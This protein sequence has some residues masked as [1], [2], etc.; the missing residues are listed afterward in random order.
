M[1]HE[2]LIAACKSLGATTYDTRSWRHI[3]VL[4]H[5]L[6]LIAGLPTL[7]RMYSRS[8]GSHVLWVVIVG[9]Y[10]SNLRFPTTAG[11]SYSGNG[12]AEDP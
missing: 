3:E 9:D 8:R 12:L 11:V 5:H 1:K 4:C 6:R 2:P 10:G 7:F